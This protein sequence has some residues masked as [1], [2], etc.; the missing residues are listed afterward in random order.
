[1][2]CVDVRPVSS[3]GGGGE[4]FVA[5]VGDERRCRFGCSSWMRAWRGWRRGGFGLR[6]T[7]ALA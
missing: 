7:M 1:M 2:D 5:Y 6:E 3:W 4:D